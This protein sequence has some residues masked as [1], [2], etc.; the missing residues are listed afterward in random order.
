MAPETTIPIEIQ[1]L[2]SFLKRREILEN[3]EVRRFLESAST[4]DQFSSVMLEI[5]LDHLFAP[6][7]LV[8]Y[9][10]S[11]LEEGFSF[12]FADRY[13]LK[14]GW[15][16]SAKILADFTDRG[17]LQYN[18]PMW[19]M[20]TFIRQKVLERFSFCYPEE[21]AQATEFLQEIRTSRNT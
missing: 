12:V 18:E 20:P 3:K 15:E 13:L 4:L 2:I 5:S 19:V 9:H 8:F 7:R 11:L 10:L 17:L 14:I 1:R 6:E 16:D 21:V